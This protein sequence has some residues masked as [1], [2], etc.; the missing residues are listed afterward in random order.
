MKKSKWNINENVA[1]S[2]CSSRFVPILCFPIRCSAVQI[3]LQR[4]P[5]QRNS[6]AWPKASRWPR[7][8]QWLLGTPVVKRTWSPPLTLADEPSLT[9][10]T[11]AKWDNR[12]TWG[13]TT[14]FKCAAYIKIVKSYG[15][16]CGNNEYIVYLFMLT[17]RKCVMF[18]LCCSASGIPP[19]GE[20]WCSGS[21]AA[22][23]LWMCH[24]LP[25]PSGACVSGKLEVSA[26]PPCYIL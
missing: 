20:P 8:K 19:G 12:H 4:H 13:L 11:P 7:L 15:I 17:W 6:S 26:R 2:L 1:L 14:P 22:L 16:I 23:R 5:L 24:W 3:L 10:C 25:G 9:C 21:S 18:L